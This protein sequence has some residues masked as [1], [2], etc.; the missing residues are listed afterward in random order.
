M[1]TLKK[2]IKHTV[3]KS[4]PEIQNII[5]YIKNCIKI[6]VYTCII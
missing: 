1:I 4:Y 6:H 5:S 2:Y 3:L